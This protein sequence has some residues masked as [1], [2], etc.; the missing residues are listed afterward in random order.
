M[1]G[2]IRV[3]RAAVFAADDDVG[4]GVASCWQAVSNAGGAV[5]FPFPPVEDREVAAATARLAEEVAAGSVRLHLA[6]SDDIVVGWVVLRLNQAP[7]AGHWARVERLQRRPD[8][9]GRGIGGRLL[10]AVSDD[11]RSLGIEHLHLVLRGGEDLERFYVSHGW[12]EIGRH[13]GA[14]R[15]ADDDERDEVAMMLDLVRTRR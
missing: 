15:L 13:P 12:V 4:R 9:W 5:G 6:E 7:V 8:W 10:E 3:R 1:A 2:S 11:A 14:L